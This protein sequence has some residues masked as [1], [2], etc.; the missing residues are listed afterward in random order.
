VAVRLHPLPPSTVTAVGSSGD[1]GAV[2]RA[3]TEL[4][5][6]R[7]EAQCLDVAWGGDA[8]RVLARF[9]GSEAAVQARQAASILESAGLATELTED[10]EPLWEAQRRAQRS[11]DGMAVR[12]SGVQTQIADQMRAAQRAGA[13][14]VG[15]AAYGLAWIALPNPSAEAVE[16]L[17]R[18][19]SPSP[20]VVLDAPRTLRERLDVWGVADSPAVELMRRVKRRFDPAGACSPGVLVGGI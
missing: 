16:S 12:V 13:S 15:R 8:G 18:E 6:A 10:D 1:P 4:T 14:L 5:H 20:C 17:R 9:A 3:A 7:S 11:T 19:L 2:A